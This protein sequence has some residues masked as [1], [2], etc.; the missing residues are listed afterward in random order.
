MRGNGAMDNVPSRLVWNNNLTAMATKP[1]GRRAWQALLSLSFLAVL[2]PVQLHAADPVQ[3]DVENGRAIAETD[4]KCIRCHGP[5]GVSDDPDTPHLAGQNPAYLL[6]QMRDF[7]SMERLGPNMFKRVRRLSE[8]Q[9]ADIARWYASQ[10]LPETRPVDRLAL[11]VPKLVHS[12]DPGRDIPPCELC[13]ARDGRSVSGDIPVLAGQ[14]AD[15]LISAME[16]FREGVRTNDPGEFMETITKKMSD[17]E[18]EVLARYYAAL[19]G[20]PAE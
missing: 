15:Y 2:L 9:M 4:R 5:N 16:Y 14:S 12:G 10:T 7:K 17:T 19:G 8:Q 13:H 18:Y 1:E 3:G 6:K 11:R 20:R